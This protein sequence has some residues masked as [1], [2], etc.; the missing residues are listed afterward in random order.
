MEQIHILENGSGGIVKGTVSLCLSSV[1][2]IS[3]FAIFEN[4]FKNET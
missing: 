4:S 1:W 2:A 3:F